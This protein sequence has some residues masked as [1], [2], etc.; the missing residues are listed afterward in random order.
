M[1]WWRGVVA[2]VVVVL[3][4]IA[5]GLGFQR[6]LVYFPD[7]SRPDVARALP[8]AD[9]VSVTTHDGLELRAWLLAPASPEEPTV[10]VL[11]GNA[12]NRASRAPLARALADRGLGVLLTDYRGYGGNPGAPTEDDLV[13]D[14]VAWADLLDARDDVGPLVYL[15]ESLGGG[16]ATALAVQRPPSALVLRS[17]FTSLHDVAR[18]HYGWVP[19]FLLLD[20]YPVEEHVSEVDAP[21][22]VVTGARDEIV[23]AALSRRV[24]EAAGGPS[25]Y[26]EVPGLRH[27]DA[28]VAAGPALADELVR[29]VREHVG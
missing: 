25:R 9:E 16:V 29:F 19:V 2:T 23:P 17:P 13:A 5:V 6:R 11:P 27:N 20:R 7:T 4:V 22:L 15:G 8:G 28:E 18:F 26:V 12:G 21:V 10:L 14:A 3:V 24:A 1:R